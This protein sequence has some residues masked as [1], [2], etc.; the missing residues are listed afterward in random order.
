MVL[1]RSAGVRRR[2]GQRELEPCKRCFYT[3]ITNDNE[4]LEDVECDMHSVRSE[5]D[6]LSL[7]AAECDIHSVRYDM[8]LES[9]AGG[10]LR[11]LIRSPTTLWRR[12]YIQPML[13]QGLIR[14]PT[15][16]KRR[17]C[18]QREL[19]PCKRCFYAITT[20]YYGSLQ[21]VDC[22]VLSV[23][24]DMVHVR[25]AGVAGDGLIRSPSATFYRRRYGHGE[26][27]PCKRCFSILK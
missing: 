19:E 14:S 26:L 18:G 23:R 6:P 16:L 10:R 11:C 15:S 25:S 24:Y 9:V 17:L 12:P 27:E 21:A 2:Y 5:Y 8:V 3:I 7:K 22:D 13:E 20:N 1:V 4:S